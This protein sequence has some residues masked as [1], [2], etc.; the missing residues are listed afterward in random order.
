[1]IVASDIMTKAGVQLLDEDHIR[2]PLAELAGWIN[3]GVQA[4]VLA[5]P[6]ASCTTVALPLQKGTRQILPD[7]IDDKATLQLVGINRN[8]KGAAEPREG[9]RAIR[10]AA[11]ALLDAQEPN[12]HDP[13][14][15]PFRREVRQV[16]YDENVPT[17]FYVYPGNDGT[18]LVEAA[19]STLP[20]PVAP[21]PDADPDALA[22]WLAPV[23]LADPYSGP[24]LDYVLSRCHQK[25]DTAADGVKA[26]SHYQ[27]FAA[28]LGI[29]VQ[30]E[31]TSNPNRRR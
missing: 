1:M 25:D 24:L 8:L 29:K 14:Y 7:A 22:S 5:K 9:G 12:W 11:R 30:S 4:I 19:V 18:G 13:S 17:E 20:P 27:L 16:I 28:A 23:G 6:S 31:G 15:V 2:W 21:A 26:Q 3:E 10:T